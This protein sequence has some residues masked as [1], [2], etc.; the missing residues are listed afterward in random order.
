MASNLNAPSEEALLSGDDREALQRL[1]ST[2]TFLMIGTQ[3]AGTTWLSERLHE[4]ED[5]F[6]PDVKE[7]QF[8]NVNANYRKGFAWYA[9]LFEEASGHRAVG[10]CTP[11]YLWAHCNEVE[12]AHKAVSFNVA[13]RVYSAFPDIR[14]VIT[15]RDPVARAVSA[16]HHF[17]N[18]GWIAPWRPLRDAAG[19]YGIASRGIYHLQLKPWFRLYPA[20]RRKIFIYEEDIRPDDRKPRTAKELF[21]FLGLPVPAR[22]DTLYKRVNARRGNALAWLNQ[23]PLLRERYRGQ[24]LARWID[25][26]TP[27]LVQSWLEPKIHPADIDALREMYEPHNRKLE[28]LLGRKL[29]W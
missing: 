16:Y 29:P 10:E 20:S 12:R 5:A 25:R 1:Q 23:V 18:R 27:K 21:R 26:M 28:D 11:D 13:E 4:H 7:A 19:E 15:L 22:M 24:Q 8:F 9:S 14:I 2:M 6:V 17:T 3:K